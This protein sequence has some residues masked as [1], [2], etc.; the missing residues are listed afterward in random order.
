MADSTPL[1]T[2][3]A[4]TQGEQG[5]VWSVLC[6]LTPEQGWSPQLDTSLSIPLQNFGMAAASYSCRGHI[7]ILA[8]THAF[9]SSPDSQLSLLRILLLEHFTPSVP[10]PPTAYTPPI[11]FLK[12]QSFGRLHW[13][14]YEKD[15]SALQLALF[16]M[17][18]SLPVSQL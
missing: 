10:L 14:R 5:G 6:C 3:S 18:R 13:D 11:L 8:D 7:S 1:N 16:C 12:M 15:S 2:R 17:D 9:L 4:D